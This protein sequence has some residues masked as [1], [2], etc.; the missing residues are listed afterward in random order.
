MCE[1]NPITHL[2]LIE[3][4]IVKNAA[5]YITLENP[6]GQ[7]LHIDYRSS[8]PTNYEIIPEKIVI[9]PF[10]S[11]RV[12][13]QYSPSNLDIIE[14]STIVLDNENVGKWKYYC[15]CIRLLPTLMEPQP[16]STSVRNSTSSMLSFKNPFRESISVTVS[17]EIRDSLIFSLLLKRNKFNIAQMGIL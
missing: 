1:D 8:N 3:C 4:E 15:K 12:C 13:I 6:T 9:P 5:Q 2:D 11:I 14:N 7:E 10:E 17:L 16:I